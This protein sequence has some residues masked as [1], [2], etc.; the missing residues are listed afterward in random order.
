MARFPADDETRMIAPSPARF[1]TGTAARARWKTAWTWTPKAVSQVSGVISRR[2]PGTGPPAEWTMTSRR[3]RS[4]VVR[5]TDIV[6]SAA[7]ARSAGG[8]G[9][10]GPGCSPAGFGGGASLVG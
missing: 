7:L 10:L 4:L 1:M 8:R 3:P 5:S 6:A 9:L 2:P